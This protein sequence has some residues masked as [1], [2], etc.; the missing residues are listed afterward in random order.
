MHHSKEEMLP[1]CVSQQDNDPKC[2]RNW[3]A[4]LFQTDGIS[5]MVGLSQSPDLRAIENTWWNQKCSPGHD[6]KRLPNAMCGS[7]HA[8]QEICHVLS[9][10]K[11][12]WRHYRRRINVAYNDGMKVPRR[13]CGGQMFASVGVPSCSAVLS[14]LMYRCVC[15]ISVNSIF[16]MPTN[17]ASWVFS[18]LLTKWWCCPYVNA[19]FFKN[20]FV[21]ALSP[22]TMNR[23]RVLNKIL[24][25]TECAASPFNS[26]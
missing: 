8:N 22:P 11:H 3:A 25:W 24:S 1:W 2:T 21:F 20:V 9:L 26:F 4:S 18:D 12:L 13:S 5:V 17:P 10:Y 23:M 7:K 19:R 6:L 16:F 14:N 15:T